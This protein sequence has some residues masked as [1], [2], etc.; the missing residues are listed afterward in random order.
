MI[1]SHTAKQPSMGLAISTPPSTPTLSGRFRLAFNISPLSI[2]Y[3]RIFPVCYDPIV[4]KL[5]HP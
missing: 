2:M 1:F 5:K 3:L 4:V